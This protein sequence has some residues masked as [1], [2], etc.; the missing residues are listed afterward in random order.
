MDRQSVADFIA[1][2]GAPAVVSISDD[3]H[4]FHFERSGFWEE[5]PLL[6][7]NRNGHY[8]R[9]IQ[10]PQGDFL[11]AKTWTAAFETKPWEVE[12]NL[13]RADP[14]ALTRLCGIGPQGTRGK[15]FE[16]LSL[17]PRDLT[18][19]GRKAVY[20]QHM[21]DVYFITGNDQFT[22]TRRDTGERKTFAGKLWESQEASIWAN[23]TFA[24]VPLK[25]VA[26]VKRGPVAA[27][28]LAQLE[29]N[30]LWGAF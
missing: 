2:N 13:R 5:C 8:F 6:L 22:L 27:E 18:T 26:A 16:T 11:F 1:L 14:A 3:T 20:R 19:G 24:N 15:P 7:V 12:A 23:E 25:V 4:I 28:A 30:P 21:M 29:E 10:Q 9:L 17:L